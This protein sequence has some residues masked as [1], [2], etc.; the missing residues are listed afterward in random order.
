MIDDLASGP[1]LAIRYTKMAINNWIEEGVN[2][3]LRELLA[4]EGISSYQLDHEEAVNA[5]L[6]D[7]TPNFPS[8]RDPGE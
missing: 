2:N 1:K 7:R 4:L 5:F 8:G 6:E 3:I